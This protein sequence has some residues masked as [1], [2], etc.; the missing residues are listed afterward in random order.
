MASGPETLILAMAPGPAS[1]ARAT[2]VSEYDMAQKYEFGDRCN[3]SGLEA[4]YRVYHQ[5][6]QKMEVITQTAQRK[7]NTLLAV[8]HLMQLLAYFTGFGG[9]IVPLILWAVCKDTVQGMD[10]HGKAVIEL[11]LSLLLYI[12]ISIPPILVCG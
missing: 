2:M 10:V 9:F 8:T 11:Q 12:L 7:D 4:T 3:I 1:P 5:I 6:N